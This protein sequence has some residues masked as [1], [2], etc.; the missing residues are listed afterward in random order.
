MTE[1]ER[2]RRREADLAALKNAFIENAGRGDDAAA[3][4]SDADRPYVAGALAASAAAQSA[5]EQDANTAG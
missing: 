5:G 3:P 2:G 1:A 4:Q